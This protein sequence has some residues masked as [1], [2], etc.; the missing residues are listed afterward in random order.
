[1]K[2]FARALL[3]LLSVLAVAALVFVMATGSPAG[4]ATSG[5]SLAHVTPDNACKPNTN[6]FYTRDYDENVYNYQ[7]DGGTTYWFPPGIINVAVN[8]CHVRV[9]MHQYSGKPLCFNPG[10][11]DGDM[12]IT[13]LNIQITSTTDPCP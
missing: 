4:A 8:F 10:Q 9:W 13:P 1:M 11:G 7:C 5:T 2:E 3:G 6:C 12:D